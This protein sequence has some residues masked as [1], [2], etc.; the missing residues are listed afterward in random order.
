[1]KN[2]KIYFFQVFLSIAQRLKKKNI[3][4]AIKGKKFDG[5]NYINKAIKK[6]ATIIVTK[7]KN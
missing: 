4:F 7:K 1:M 6:G 2:L 3:F 5:N